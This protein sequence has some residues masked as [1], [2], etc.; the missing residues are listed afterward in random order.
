MINLSKK[1]KGI[2]TNSLYEDLIAWLGFRGD[3][4]SLVVNGSLNGFEFGFILDGYLYHTIN[5]NPSKI[6]PGVLQDLG[7]DLSSFIRD[8][9]NEN[10]SLIDNEEFIYFDLL[11]R[12]LISYSIS[13]SNLIQLILI[14]FILLIIF[15]R[16]II[17]RIY[18]QKINENCIWNCLEYSLKKRFLIILLI[19][20]R[21][22]GSIFI[23]YLFSMMVG[24]I[25]S[26]IHPLISYG[27]SIL[28]ILIYSIPSLIG[29]ISINLIGNFILNKIKKEMNILFEEIC[30]ILILNLILMI[31]SISLN[32]RLLYLILIWSIFLCPMYILII[33]IELIIHYKQIKINFFVIKLNLW[34]IVILIPL[35]HTIDIVDRLMRF[36]IPV[37]S[38]R[39]SY[40]YW[41]LRG[42][43]ILSHIGSIPVL[44]FLINSFPIFYKKKSFLRFL[45]II[46]TMIYLI[47]IL[48]GFNRDIYDPNHP[49]VYYV[50]H[51]SKS[52]YKLEKLLNES[53]IAS[54]KYQSSSIAMNTYDGSALLPILDE[55]SLKSGYLL[56]N[57]KC[58]TKTNCRFDDTFNRSIAFQMISIEYLT[59]YTIRIEHL[60]SYHIKVSSIYPI[61]MNIENENVIPRNETLIHIQINPL[62]NSFDIDIQIKR[63][64][65]NDSPFLL[66]FHRLM[67]NMA[68]LGKGQCQSIDDQAILII[69]KKY[70]FQN[71]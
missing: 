51:R 20:L 71:F 62:I 31:I 24:G 14:I 36:L 61:E 66:L 37:L 38:R 57:I 33:I 52:I 19:I 8:L 9:L 7:N 68:L 6:K 12:Y 2:E 35:I 1:L 25:L 65:L 21:N 69:D 45:L 44:L 10:S 39:F 46:L 63:C 23:G 54:L 53:S 29:S 55:F 16:I 48:I 17:D 34:L 64:H 22:I 50:R 58:S 26:I 56:S 40:P 41:S 3:Y 70:L 67:T 18:H 11:S 4:D 47:V 28:A 27:N 59:N 15:I 60:L 30:S 42:N 43:L 5:D 32:N 13:K 49:N